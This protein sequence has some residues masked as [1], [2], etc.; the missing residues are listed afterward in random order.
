[1]SESAAADP[2]EDLRWMKAA[3]NL[4]SRSLGL[5]APNP[6]VG[7]ILVKDPVVV[8]R[9]ATAPGGRPH[10]ERIALEQAGEAAR[11]ATLY[12]TL[13]PCSHFGASP[14]C[15]DA[16]IAGGVTRVVSAM[17]DP[18]PLVGGQGH[19][20]LRE[21]GIAVSVGAGAA[22]A[23]RD[24]L[25]HILRVTAERPRVTLKLAETADGFASASANDARL[26]ITGPIADLRVQIMR[27]THEAIMVGIETALIDDPALT[28][29]L[30]GL[31]RKPL[32]VVLD[33]HLRLSARS[34]LAATAGEVPTMIIAGAG[35]PDELAWRLQDLG[36]MI[37]RLPLDAEAHVDL[38]HALRAL[39]GRGIT[40]VFSEGGPKVA[41]R[42]I[43]LGLA[44]EVALITAKK[45]LGRAGVAALDPDARGALLDRSHYRPVET[46]DYGPDTMRLWE[47]TGGS[48]RAVPA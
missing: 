26:R 33:T 46:L 23:R 31:D 22:Q 21:A 42:L 47:R 36:M 19:T 27:S 30:P 25:G 28:V 16:V 17:E 34:R 32:R 12:V 24:H 29:R 39:A 1:M 8:G 20:R 15:V 35:A 9:G 2:N 40:R 10:A 38:H 3:L 45:P 14:P 37:E 41:A 18:N 11:G 6:A 48:R 7:A 13:E 4:G 43:G 5:T 44:D